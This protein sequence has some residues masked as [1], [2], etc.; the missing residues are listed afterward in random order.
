MDV[1]KLYIYEVYGQAK[2]I[3]Y[4]ERKKTLNKK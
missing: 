2:G 4:A 3:V 1:N